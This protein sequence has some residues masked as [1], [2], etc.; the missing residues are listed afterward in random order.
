MQMEQIMNYRHQF[1]LSVVAVSLS[2][3]LV[4]AV[5]GCSKHSAAGDAANT[6]HHVEKPAVAVTVTPIVV[7]SLERTVSL[8]GSF[9]GQE[10]VTIAPNP[11]DEC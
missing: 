1:S 10:E 2:A 4:F 8:V 6:P 11:R 5:T 3:L 9:S 7:R